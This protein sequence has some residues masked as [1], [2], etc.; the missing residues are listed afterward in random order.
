MTEQVNT[1][2]KYFRG[3][4]IPI[5]PSIQDTLE[6]QERRSSGSKVFSA[7]ALKVPD[8][9]CEADMVEAHVSGTKIWKS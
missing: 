9:L 6:V 7:C 1:D 2:S 3:K 5:F 4:A 8:L